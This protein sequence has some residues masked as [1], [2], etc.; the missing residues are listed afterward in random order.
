MS[1][2]KVIKR[3]QQEEEFS[4]EKITKVL[5]WAVSG[6][7][8]V[9]VN[10]I[11]AN[12]KIHLR[13]G[14]STEE[15]HSVLIDTTEEMISEFTPNYQKVAANL[16]NY[17][18][19]KNIWGGKNPPK[20][21]DF[22]TRNVSR[23]V[24]HPEILEMYS[25]EDFDKLDEVIDHDRDFKFP[26]SGLRQLCDKYLVQNRKT[27]EIFETPQFAYMAIAMVLFGSYPVKDRI[28]YVKKA[29][30]MYSR[31]KINLPTPL[32]AGVRTNM[33]QYS[34]CCIID[35][36]DTMDSIFASV[37]SVGHATSRRFGI[38]LNIGRMR[39]IGSEIRNGDVIHTG[40]IP[41]LKIFESAVKSCQQNG[42]RGGSATCTTVI[43]HY[44][45]EDILQLKNNAGTENNRVRKLDYSIAMSQ[46]FYERMRKDEEI[47]LFSPHEVPDLYEAYGHPEFDELYLAKEKDPSIKM[48]KKIRGSELSSLLVK[49][50]VETGRVYLFNI[51][52]MNQR[53]AWADKVY[54][55]NLCLEFAAPTIPQKSFNDPDAEIGIC[56]LGAINATEVTLSEMPEVCDIMVRSL[57]SVISHQEY[58]CPAAERFAVNRRSLGVGITN[59]AAL[60]ASKGIRYDDTE[61][62]NVADELMESVQYYLIQ[63]SCNLAKEKG[64]CANFKGSKYSRGWLPLDTYKKDIDAVV[65]RKPTLDWEALRAEVAEH[66]MRNST[67]SAIM[68]VESSSVIQGSTNGIE[69]PRSLITY[70]KSKKGFVPCFVPHFSS[71]KKKYTLAFDMKNNNGII[72]V[73]GAF[74]KWTDMSISAN[75]YYNYDNYE[76]GKIPDREVFTDMLKCYKMGWRSRYYLNTPDGDDQSI[77]KEEKG[78]SCESGAC[79]L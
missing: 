37:S 23:G 73:V 39:A 51:D 1:Q 35:C 32:M 77:G 55:N 31:H 25:R 34:S 28:K 7:S 43:W 58:F 66:G 54:F 68:P 59:F 61:A 69:P 42:I 52:H 13:N 2:I 50:T 53:G 79:A 16:L 19:R 56:T 21:F 3:N 48:K 78:S 6:V 47:T 12:V 10:Q 24:Y 18:I 65:T 62:P 36:D 64:R 4:P 22:V 30:N 71:W 15:I 44:E 29:Y 63:A 17:Q 60:L 8:G 9:S 20:L 46:L 5:D 70:K 14:I 57:D 72:N 75:L 49:E 40:V 45:I 26:Y 27:K 67:L 74:Q 41:F 76:G 33:K 38:G 11:E